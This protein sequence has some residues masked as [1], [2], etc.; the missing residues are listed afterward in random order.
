MAT[1]SLSWALLALL[2]TTGAAAAQ[3][4]MSIAG[5]I[6][7]HADGLPVPGARVSVAGT[8]VAVTTDA[9]GRYAL[10]AP[11]SSVRGGRIRLKVDALGQPAKTIDVAADGA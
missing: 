10:Q 7:T 3:E 6:T 2:M 11:R 5:V 8:D 1:R 9:D 4:A